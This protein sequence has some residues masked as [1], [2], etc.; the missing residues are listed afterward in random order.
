[1]RYSTATALFVAALSAGDAMAGPAHAH[2]HQ[3]AHEKRA[4]D[5]STIDYSKLDVDWAAAYAKGQAE[6][7][8]SAAAGTATTT[9]VKGAVFAAQATS[10]PAAVKT[11]VKTSATSSAKPASTSS[12]TSSGSSTG[13]LNGIVGVSNSLTKFGAKSG[14]TYEVGDLAVNNVGS[15]YGSNVI[16]VDSVGDYPFTATFV[17]PQSKAITIN[18]WNKVGSDGQPMSGSTDAPKKTTLTFV[19]AAGASQVVAIDENSNIGWVE[20]TTK[21]RSDSGAF[22]TSFG[23]A[24][25]LAAGSGYDLSAIPNTSGNNYNM[26]ITSKEVTCISDMT[27]NYWLTATQ[28]IGTSDGSCY[29]PSSTATLKVVMA[30]NV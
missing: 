4:V 8:A 7:S 6:K 13:L 28:P 12:T 30:G 18:I 27:Q 9:Q 16:K 23:E 2:L 1:M 25:F 29:V 19:L 24:T 22:D 15:P 20:A 5:Y 26:S 10:S 11:S 21:T 3:R 14:S 17:N